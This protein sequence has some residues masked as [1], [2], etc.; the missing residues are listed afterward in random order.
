MQKVLNV[1]W[2]DA[3]LARF[4]MFVTV[5]VGVGAMAFALTEI[6]V[7]FWFVVFAM[8]GLSAAF[9]PPIICVLFYKGIT[10]EGALAGMVGGFAT[11]MLWV[12]FMKP[13]TYDLVE[14]IPAMIVGFGLIFLVSSATR[15]NHSAN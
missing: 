8:S 5:A 2:Q 3:Q 6:K 4:G 7:I 12:T 13:Y 14:I 10:K 9:G 15:Q 1:G 11:D